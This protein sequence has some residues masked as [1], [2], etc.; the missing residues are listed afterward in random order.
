M[1]RQHLKLHLKLIIRSVMGVSAG[2]MLTGCSLELFGF[3]SAARA[4]DEA[5][6]AATARAAT[7]SANLQMARA[8]FNNGNY[9]IAISHLERELALRPESIAALNGLGASYD[10]L[11]RFDVAQRYYFRALELAPDPATTLAN[12][13]YSNQLQGNAS[14]A[15][16][17]L[18]LALYYDPRNEVARTNMDAAMSALSANLASLPDDQPATPAVDGAVA[19]PAATDTAITRST[20][21]GGAVI[22][23]ATDRSAPR[24]A[25]FEITNG[26]GVGG[27]A[28]ATSD[29]LKQKDLDVALVSNAGHFNHPQT[30]IEYHP[31]F[32][33]NAEQLADELGVN[34]LYRVSE[35]LAQADVRAVLGR[36]FSSQVVIRDGQLITP[37]RAPQT[38]MQALRVEVSN[39]NGVNG[40]AARV[41]SILK[42]RSG[43]LASGG[44]VVRL[45]N[46]DSFNYQ[47]TVVY[48]R[49]GQAEAVSQLLHSLPL[50]N[51]RL[52]E[53]DQLAPGVD[54]RVLL[55]RDYIP[56]DSR[57]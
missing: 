5:R 17:I 30:V 35:T 15:A 11:G 34:A 7:E 31:A 42:E 20:V 27:L 12:L 53:S 41:R 4:E 44:D 25:V 13:G 3:K 6:A 51:L 47:A 32:R 10:Q 28:A 57:G 21:A 54:V 48:Y 19:S 14:E 56:Y 52:E 29:W 39:G 45:T 16:Q 33:Q 49:R 9:G 1:S 22:D 18:E 8:A 40:M 26:A 23:S 46:A 50:Q 43:L 38:V 36:D 2:L 37:D 55:G 24:A